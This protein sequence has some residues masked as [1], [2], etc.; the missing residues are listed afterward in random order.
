MENIDY[1]TLIKLVEKYDIE[2]SRVFCKL[3]KADQ[4]AKTDILGYGTYSAFER[5]EWDYSDENSIVV[6]Y[7]DYGYD[8]YESNRSSRTIDCYALDKQV[9]YENINGDLNASGRIIGG[10]ID[11]LKDLIGTKYDGTLDFIEKAGLEIPEKLK[12]KYLKSEKGMMVTPKEI[13]NVIDRAA[14]LLAMSINS[15]LQPDIPPEDI[16]AIVS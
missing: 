2:A 12:Q 8:L 11:V 7:Y 13:D 5:I 16:L 15:A 10:C 3:K 1:K 6:S 9:I 14:S 4:G